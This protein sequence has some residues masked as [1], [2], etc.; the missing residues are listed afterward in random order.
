MYTLLG[1][2]PRASCKRSIHPTH[3]A[4][5]EPWAGQFFAVGTVLGVVRCHPPDDRESIPSLVT[6]PKLSPHRARS[7][8][9]DSPECGVGGQR[10]LNCNPGGCES[11]HELPPRLLCILE[12]C[13]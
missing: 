11:G 4:I 6:K 12:G 1:I 9:T 10:P 7:S 2:D 13:M 8:L 5:S 3:Q